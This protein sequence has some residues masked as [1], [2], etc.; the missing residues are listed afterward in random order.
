MFS[1]FSAEEGIAESNIKV[2]VQEGL[3]DRGEQN[4]ILA[5]D[6]CAVLLKLGGTGKVMSAF[7]KSN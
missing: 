7:M 1:L 4:L 3:G 5:K 6:A 2:L